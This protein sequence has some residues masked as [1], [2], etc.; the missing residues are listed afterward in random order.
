MV[1]PGATD[2]STAGIPADGLQ[3]C[4]DVAIWQANHAQT[5]STN[6]YPLE[7]FAIRNASY[8]IVINDFE[9]Y[10]APSNACVATSTKEF[11][12]INENVPLP[13][14]DNTN[15]LATGNPL[16][17]KQKKNYNALTV[18]LAQILASQ[19][20]CPGDVNLDGVVNNADIAQWQFFQQ[21]SGYSSWA[22]INLDGLTDSAD[23]AII[24]Q[25]QGACP[26][27]PAPAS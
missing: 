4:C 16:N 8:K 21:L 7:A 18:Q 17:R 1:G 11:Y 27:P 12:R 6:I 15:L 22:D 9:A 10:D 5:I 20:A 25:N 23:L 24:L 2:P 26:A 19:P 14:L 13:M 3:L